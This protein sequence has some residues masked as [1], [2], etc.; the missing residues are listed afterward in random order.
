MKVTYKYF[1]LKNNMK[2]CFE[3]YLEYLESQDSNWK[4]MNDDMKRK[5]S[6]MTFK[7]RFIN[8]AWM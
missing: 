1:I 5:Y 4:Y 3:S 6:E 2:D 7:S 8:S